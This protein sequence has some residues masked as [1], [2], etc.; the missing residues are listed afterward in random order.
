MFWYYPTADVIFIL[1]TLNSPATASFTSQCNIL[2]HFSRNKSARRPFVA[3]IYVHFFSF[4]VISF[5]FVYVIFFSLKNNKNYFS[6]CSSCCFTF[7]EFGKAVINISQ[8]PKGWPQRDTL[9]DMFN[10]DFEIITLEY[11]VNQVQNKAAISSP[12]SKDVEATNHCRLSGFWRI[13][14]QL[15]FIKIKVTYDV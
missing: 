1:D 15:C 10:F 2:S 5:S 4:P 6:C 13:N 14:P 9:R 7:I 8:F 11:N 12:N 3:L